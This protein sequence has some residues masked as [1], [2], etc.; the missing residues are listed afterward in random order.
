MLAHIH[1]YTHINTYMQANMGAH[2]E[3][4]TGSPPGPA[5]FP[6]FPAHRASAFHPLLHTLMLLLRHQR[7]K[8]DRMLLTPPFLAVLEGCFTLL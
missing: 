4:G 2:T 7:L 6:G 3:S 5:Q 8:S 1:R